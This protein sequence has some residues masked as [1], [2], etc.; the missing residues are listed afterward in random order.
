M[1]REGQLYPFPFIMPDNLTHCFHFNLVVWF[2]Y[3]EYCWT[4]GRSLYYRILASAWAWHCPVW[5]SDNT[6]CRC[7]ACCWS[8]SSFSPPPSSPSSPT[9]TPGTS[10]QR[11]PGPWLGELYSTIKDYKIVGYEETTSLVSNWFWIG[12]L[13]I[14]VFYNPWVQYTFW[15]HWRNKDWGKGLGVS[16]E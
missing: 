13:F 1:W 3:F 7:P 16:W 12:H 10:C 9:T 8:S 2:E 14:S 6:V 11:L 5:W 4:L 15:N